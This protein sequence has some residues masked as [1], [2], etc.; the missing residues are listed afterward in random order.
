M[1]AALGAV[2]A[3][4]ATPAEA[5]PT[6]IQAVQTLNQ[7]QAKFA[8]QINWQVGDYHKLQVQ[9]LLPGEGTKEVTKDEPSQ[10]GVWYTQE[11]S[12]LGQKQKTEALIDRAT[13]K[14]LKLIVNGQEQDPNQGG[15]IEI[16]EQS[17]TTITVPAGTFD[18]FY[19]KANVKA[20]GQTTQ[21]ELWINPIN[22]NIDG[23]LKMTMQSQM[24]P[25]SL[26]L[27]EFGHR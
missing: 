19:I 9:F 14:T 17:E 5:L 18:C 8:N 24:G 11:I 12:L 22:V 2:S 1:M 23:T 26:I 25:I 27:K 21:A 3:Q 4:A 10:N 16:V 7:L 6:V 20:Q 13:G 15:D